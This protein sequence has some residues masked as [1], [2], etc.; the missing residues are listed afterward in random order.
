MSLNGTFHCLRL[1][2]KEKKPNFSELGAFDFRPLRSD[3][4]PLDEFL[5]L[6]SSFVIC[7]S[8]KRWMPMQL[9]FNQLLILQLLLGTSSNPRFPLPESP[10]L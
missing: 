9:Y 6:S 7:S 10:A 2:L 5:A 4:K 3:K 8:Q 1:G